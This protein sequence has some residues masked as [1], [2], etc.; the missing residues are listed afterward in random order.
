MIEDTIMFYLFLF[1]TLCVCVWV[2]WT[3]GLL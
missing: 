3:A 1:A 2:A